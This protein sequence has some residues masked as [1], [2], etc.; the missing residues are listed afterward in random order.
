[1]SRPHRVV[2]TGGEQR[3]ND[4]GGGWLH[5]ISF[6]TRQAGAESRRGAGGATSSARSIRARISRSS[7]RAGSARSVAYH[8]RRDVGHAVHQGQVGLPESP[9]TL[10]LRT[11]ARDSD[12]G[13]LVG[14]QEGSDDV[15]TPRFRARA[16]R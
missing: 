11:F 10:P 5:A 8:S 7:D 13:V 1:M 9:P 3:R 6:Q 16:P 2:G 14:D 12:G 15:S 4:P